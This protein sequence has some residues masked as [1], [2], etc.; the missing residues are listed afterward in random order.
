MVYIALRLVMLGGVWIK[1]VSR[2]HGLVWE[3]GRKNHNAIGILSS[4]PKLS[5]VPLLLTQSPGLDKKEALCESESLRLH[6]VGVWFVRGFFM[7]CLAGIVRA[8]LPA[9]G[10]SLARSVEFSTSRRGRSC[11]QQRQRV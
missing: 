1:K 10:R 4:V 11:M 7:S 2:R 6:P 9:D 3:G 8:F 5:S